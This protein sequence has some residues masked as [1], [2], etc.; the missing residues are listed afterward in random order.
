LILQIDIWVQ[1]QKRK[2]KMYTRKPVVAGY[3]YPV[4]Q[5]EL[6]YELEEYMP[7]SGNLNAYGAI[8]PHAGY[9]YS[10]NVAGAV[11][12]KIKPK[13]IYILL[14]PNHTGYGSDI[15]IMTE[16]EWEIPLGKIKIHTELAKKIIENS[17]YAKEDIQA[18]IYEHSL[19]VQLPFIY[20]TNSD[21][22]IIP[23]AIKM[24]S[25][26]S[27]ISLAKTISE[28]IQALKLNEKVILIS[29]TD[30]SHYLPDDLAREVDALAIEK[31]KNFDPEGLYNTVLKNKISMCG[32]LSTVIMLYA[33]K[34]LGAKE[35][36]IVKYATSAEVSRDYDRVVGYLGALVL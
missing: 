6:L 8:C 15:A 35:V 4:N 33:T 12:T 31:I 34:L 10:G 36:Q 2:F 25:L 30:M 3:F 18:H 27:C 24:V 16:G 26:K 9:V 1:K 32:F 7:K 28:S 21:A 29:S 5:R 20:K 22:K 23:I 13:D 17:E 11:Y 19:E 14:G